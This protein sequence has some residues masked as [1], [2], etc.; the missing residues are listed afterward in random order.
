[1]VLLEKGLVKPT[2]SIDTGNGKWPMYNRIMTDHNHKTGGY[3]VLTVK[4]VLANSSNIGVSRLVDR[5][6]A[7]NPSEYV[8]QLYKMGVGKPMNLEIPGAGRPKIRHPKDKHVNWYKTALPWM[9]IGYEVQMPPI[10][11]L[12]FYNAIANNGKY[13]RPYF[14]KSISQN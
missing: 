5:Y 10:Y 13:I 1:M 8:D 14:V 3:G 4:E 2:D 12:A 11:T 9:S 6:F 7:H